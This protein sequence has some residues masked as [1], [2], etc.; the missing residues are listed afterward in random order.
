MPLALPNQA[1][2]LESRHY[3]S[4]PP[5]Q[6]AASGPQSA[7][8]YSTHQCVE[9]WSEAGP[10]VCLTLD[11]PGTSLFLSRN[12]FRMLFTTLSLSRVKT[13]VMVVKGRFAKCPH[14]VLPSTA[15]SV[16]LRP[17]TIRPE[18]SPKQWST[19]LATDATCD[20]STS[21]SVNR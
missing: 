21:S 13:K 2:K 4:Q 5:I 17:T 10:S 20:I 7:I 15:S 11:R 8:F 12:K 3:L 1:M 14:S 19:F 16:C 18:T 9:H 6:R